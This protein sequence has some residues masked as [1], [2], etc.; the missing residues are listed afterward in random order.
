MAC[1]NIFTVHSWKKL[2]N[3]ILHQLFQTKGNSQLNRQSWVFSVFPSV[4]QCKV[5]S[6]PV[7]VKSFH[8]YGKNTQKY[9]YVHL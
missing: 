7:L 4:A 2:R 9:H 6:H 3:T 1:H 8:I 5:T